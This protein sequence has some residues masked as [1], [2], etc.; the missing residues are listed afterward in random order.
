MSWDTSQDICPTI[1]CMERITDKGLVI[2]ACVVLMLMRGA[3]EPYGVILLLVG[4][5]VTA[6]FDLLAPRGT[7]ASSALVMCAGLC[8]CC[9]P[10]ATSLF[11]LVAYDLVRTP[12]PQL[13]AVPLVTSFAWAG[14]G[15]SSWIFSALA[16]VC[17]LLSALL[18][19]RT[20][21]MVE[22][23]VSLKRLNDELADR[24]LLLREKNRESEDARTLA[25]HAATLT[26]RTR[27]AREIHDGVGHTLTRLILQV[28]ALKV[29]HATDDAE[30][31]DLTELSVGLNEAL[32]SMRRSVHAL[33]DEGV[34]LRVELE[35]LTSGCADA[36]VVMSY[37]AEDE[38]P[39]EVARCIVAVAK[40]AVTNAVRHAHAQKIE[41]KFI[42]YPGLWQ[43]RVTNDGTMPGSSFSESDRGMGLRSMRERV[44]LVGGKLSYSA[45]TEF[46]VRA[47]IPR[48]ER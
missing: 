32:D 38:V 37:L 33:E 34:D 46:A 3:A 19:L 16:I 24:L 42:E 35:H 28:E 1:P 8:A 22:T 17:S 13:L 14:L 47:T 7:W 11:P 10:S 6:G 48:G 4:I 43:L 23:D 45:G 29:I 21:R 18:S 9:V 41:V 20:G 2:A 26:E 5:S 12:W 30:S 25:L 27:I 40:E 44:E 39:P 31:R 15:S 36:R